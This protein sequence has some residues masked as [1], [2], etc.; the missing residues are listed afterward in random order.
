MGCVDLVYLCMSS[1]CPDPAVLFWR[2]RWWPNQNNR[3]VGLLLD[4]IAISRLVLDFI[5]SDPDTLRPL[6]RSTRYLEEIDVIHSNSKPKS[7]NTR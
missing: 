4:N 6:G 1:S 7:S 5:I 2:R 3:L